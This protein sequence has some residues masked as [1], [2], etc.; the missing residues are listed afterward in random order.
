MGG[1]HSPEMNL[2]LS[3]MRGVFNTISEG[4]SELSMMYVISGMMEKIAFGEILR[5]QEEQY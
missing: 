2:K 1:Y 3:A 5:R 4:G